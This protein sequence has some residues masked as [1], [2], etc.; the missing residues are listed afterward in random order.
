MEEKTYQFQGLESSCLHIMAKQ[1]RPRAV[2]VPCHLG[3]WRKSDSSRRSPRQVSPRLEAKFRHWCKSDCF[4]VWILIPMSYLSYYLTMSY[5]HF[6]VWANSSYA[7]NLFATPQREKNRP[8]LYQQQ[9]REAASFP[10][11]GPG[12]SS[13]CFLQQFGGICESFNSR[14]SSSGRIHGCWTKHWEG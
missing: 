8:A 10:R 14:A 7:D 5:E 2:M 4:F 6:E 12:G 9:E 11:Q 1:R 13:L 3:G